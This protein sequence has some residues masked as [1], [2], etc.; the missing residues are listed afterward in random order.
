MKCIQN[1]RVVITIIC[2][3]FYN[4]IWSQLVNIES[5]RIQSD[6][7]RFVFNADLSYTN[8]KNNNET[9]SLFNS[10]IASQVK[11]KS[12]KDIFL[13]LMNIDYSKANNQELSNSVMTHLRYN[14][15]ISNYLRLE[16]FYQYQKNQ[17]LGI[18]YRVLLGLGPR[19]KLLNKNKT[20]VY[21]GILF[22][23]EK[24]KT[25]DELNHVIYNNFNRLSNYL[26]AAI[27]L[28]KDIGELDMVTY[29]QPCLDNFNNYRLN[30]QTS[31]IFNITSHIKL[32]N[33]IS[34]LH[35]AVPPLGISKDNLNF[36]NGIKISY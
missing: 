19:I 30:H 22:M 3:L 16:S 15:K 29:Y 7:I 12:L 1:N 27:K 2:F 23:R 13:F 26:V 24:E 32:T 34:L 10:S 28:P 36:T 35:D 20:K 11:T 31:L 14:R 5:Q 17:I 21:Y 33:T 18:D 6:S 4:T 9:L 8:Q 25:I